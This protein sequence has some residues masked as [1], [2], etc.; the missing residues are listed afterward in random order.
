MRVGLVPPTHI[1]SSRLH[2]GMTFGL[3]T[4]KT[5]RDFPFPQTNGTFLLWLPRTR[6]GLGSG[7]ASGNKLQ[8]IRTIPCTSRLDGSPQHCG[9]SAANEDDRSDVVPGPSRPSP[10]S[11]AECVS[12]AERKLAPI[13]WWR[14]YSGSVNGLAL[15]GLQGCM[16]GRGEGVETIHFCHYSV[17]VPCRPSQT[18]GSDLYIGLQ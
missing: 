13:I 3:G 7:A 12:G 10:A 17:T 1:Y 14:S 11:R 16:Q 8:N 4:H 2:G 5:K 18:S 9:S 15:L 6:C